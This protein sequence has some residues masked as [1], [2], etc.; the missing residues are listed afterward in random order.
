[1]KS[2]TR[3]IIFLIITSIIII[4]MT[5]FFSTRHST[6]YPMNTVTSTST[7]TTMKEYTLA[8][9]NKHNDIKSCWTIVRDS[10]YDLTSFIPN[11]PGGDKILAVCGID[12]TSAFTNQHDDQPKP[13]KMLAKLRIGTIRK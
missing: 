8:E 13:E 1:M 11:H 4:S 9:V 10:V 5:Y 12:G 6:V 3:I 7:P 2:T